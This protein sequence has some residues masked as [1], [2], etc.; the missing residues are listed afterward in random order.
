VQLE[1]ADAPDFERVAAFAF[2]RVDIA[3][4]TCLLDSE[5]AHF[6]TAFRAAHQRL[7][8][9]FWLHHSQMLRLCSDISQR[10]NACPGRLQ[11]SPHRRRRPVRAHFGAFLAAAGAAAARLQ[12]VE[13]KIVRK[14][15][16][17]PFRIVMAEGGKV[18]AIDQDMGQRLRA[19]IGDAR[20][21]RLI[22][23]ERMPLVP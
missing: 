14:F 15:R 23:H 12:I 13:Q 2:E 16:D 9:L 17:R 7:D 11:N 19:A 6:D 4:R 8:R 18:R 10:G 21:T 1:N 22:V 3:L 20:V 5:N